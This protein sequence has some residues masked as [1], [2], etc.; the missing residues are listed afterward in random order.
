MAINSPQK[1]KITK[2]TFHSPLKKK[3]KNKHECYYW[4]NN[5]ESAIKIQ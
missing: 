3:Y 1:W 4:N 2:L 5:F